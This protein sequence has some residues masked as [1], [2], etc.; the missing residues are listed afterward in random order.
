MDCNEI[1]SGAKK[2][3]KERKKI[4]IWRRLISGVT[5]G[6]ELEMSL[7][8]SYLYACP[9]SAHSTYI[10]GQSVASGFFNFSLS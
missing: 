7:N 9:E 4:H 8:R 5:S 2:R 1:A 10:G 6:F 3:K